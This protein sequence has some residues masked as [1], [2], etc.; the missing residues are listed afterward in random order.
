MRLV[1]VAI[2]A[3]LAATVFTTSAAAVAYGER[4][5]TADLVGLTV[6][7]FAASAALVL[8]C[9]V[10]GLWLLR[11][12]FGRKLSTLQAASAVG[13]G[14]NIP[15]FLVLTIMASQ[16][17]VFAAGE[18]VWLAILFLLF[19]LFFGVGFARYGQQAA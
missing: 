10:P 15:A 16:A 4:P 7:S 1:G 13:V 3:W 12:S 17:D 6:T 11:R 18:T 5:S 14:L 19:G 8:A 2:L 9:Y